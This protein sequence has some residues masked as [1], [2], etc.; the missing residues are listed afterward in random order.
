MTLA[1]L[2][3]LSL[4]LPAEP[5]AMPLLDFSDRAAAEAWRPVHDTVMGGVSS[6]RSRAIDGAVLF[7]GRVSLDNNGGFASFRLSEGLP[8][9][10]RRDGLRLRVRGDGQVYKLSLRTDGRWDGVSWQAPFAAPSGEGFTD[11]GNAEAVLSVTNGSDCSAGS[12]S[13]SGVDLPCVDSLTITPD[14]GT[15]D[16]DV[17]SIPTLAAGE[18]QVLRNVLFYRYRDGKIIE[19]REF[20]VIVTGPGESSG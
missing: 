10:S 19:T 17:W 2:L 11:G 18:R 9:L 7:E 3:L 6:G 8:D 5:A 4:A 20:G 14:T 16:G 1:A 12:I 15:V 13:V